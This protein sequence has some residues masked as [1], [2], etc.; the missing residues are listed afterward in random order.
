M[1]KQLLFAFGISASVLA[2]GQ[3]QTNVEL[4]TPDGGSVMIIKPVRFEITRPITDLETLY[5]AVEVD[6][7]EQKAETHNRRES[8]THTMNNPNALPQGN[9][10]LMNSGYNPIHTASPPIANWQAQSGSGYPPDPSGAAGPNHYVQAVNTTY[11]V[12]SKT[13]TGISGTLN[14]ST[15]W[16]GSTNDGD[17]IVLYDRYADR[18]LI[19]QFQISGNEILIAVS[20]T[21]DPTGAYYSWT[22]VPQAS[23]FPD[24]FK[25]SIWHD[26]Y[27]MTA[28]WNERVV[29]FDR[30]AMLAGQANPSMMVKAM[31]TTPSNGFFAPIPAD[32]DG[33]LPPAGTPALFFSFEDDGWNSSN[34]DAIRIYQMN[35]NWSSPASTTCSLVT[36]LLTSPFNAVFTSSWTDIPQPGSSQKLDAIAGIVQFRV[37]YRRWSGYNTALLCFPVK[38]S[39][40]QAVI[41]WYELRE[42]TSNSTWSI[43]QEGTYAPNTTDYFWMGALN[44]DDQGNIGM[45][46]NKS[47]ATNISP[48]LYYTGRLATDPLNQMTITEQTAQTGSGAQSGIERWGDYAHMTLDPDGYTF[49]YTGEYLASGA[50][51]TRVFSFQ[52]ATNVGIAD[53]TASQPNNVTAYQNSNTIFVN[54]TNLVN[55]DEML[56]DLFDM[57]GKLI[58]A[59][60]IVPVGNMFTTNIDVAG[61]AKGTY[62]VRVGNLGFQKVVKVSVN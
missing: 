8:R 44:M 33:Q 24:Y 2:I 50:K 52:I 53:N 6:E 39:G 11:R 10:P 7:A 5:K 22:F 57:N 43:Y 23:Q 27:Y 46:Y 17:P 31:P 60:K 55:N 45:A 56:V 3:V 42:N 47:N 34:Q 21:N 30:N 62:M 61:L 14:L 32:A 37:Q 35:T 36:T 15:L 26:G 16:S 59:N 51:R 48:G 41:R 9:D 38:G 58:S 18:W 1:K 12:Y 25:L 20:Q 54:A 19:S 28:N 49:W 13:G 4:P 40:L 29:A